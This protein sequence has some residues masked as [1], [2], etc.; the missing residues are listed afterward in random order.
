MVIAFINSVI[1]TVASVA[2]LVIFSADGRLRLA[3]PCQPAQP[4]DQ[5]PGA[6]RPDRAARRRAHHL[7]PA[8]RWVCSRPC[9]V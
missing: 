8:G 1:L 5:H 6:G 9:P 2:A 4:G 7:G 3:A